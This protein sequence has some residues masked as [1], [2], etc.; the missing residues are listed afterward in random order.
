LAEEGS[1][2]G[3]HRPPEGPD[4]GSESGLA[5]V[6][7]DALRANGIAFREKRKP[8]GEVL[9]LDHCLTSAEHAD[10]A[11]VLVFPSGAL[12]HKCQ[13]ASCAGKGWA[14]VRPLLGL[15]ENASRPR[16]AVDP[17]AIRLPSGV[18]LARVRGGGR[19]GR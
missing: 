2:A 17:D 16:T 3:T 13:H 18:V 14:D 4:P 6:V 19:G 8:W 12:A 1:P 11:A 7:R 5:R 9:E 10:G 15:R